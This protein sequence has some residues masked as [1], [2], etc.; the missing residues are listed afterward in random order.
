MKY[1]HSLY[2]GLLSLLFIGCQEEQL[3][4]MQTGGFQIS[5]Q[6][7]AADITTKTLPE[8]LEDPV[9]SNFQLKITSFWYFYL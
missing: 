5:L 3:N 1:I 6:D 8:N 4:N 2:I 9:V 7:V